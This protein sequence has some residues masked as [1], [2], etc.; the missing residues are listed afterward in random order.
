M[1]DGIEKDMVNHPEHYHG[2]KIKLGYY[3]NNDMFHFVE[4]IK[5]DV[6]GDFYFLRVDCIDVIRHVKDMRIATAIKYLW[7]VGFK[8]KW[9]NKEDVKKAIWYSNDYLNNNVIGEA[10]GNKTTV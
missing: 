10:D 5:I 9:N 6:I 2:P 7:R 4:D 8:G 1:A 3:D